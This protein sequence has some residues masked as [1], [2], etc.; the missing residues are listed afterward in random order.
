MISTLHVSDARYDSYD[1]TRVEGA[2]AGRATVH[3]GAVSRTRQQVA[4]VSIIFSTC[5]K[6]FPP[7]GVPAADPPDGELRPRGA[8]RHQ[9]ESGR[10]G[11][12]GHHPHP[13]IRHGE[14][15]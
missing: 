9:R 12:G 8:A 3:Q 7:T 11:A 2:A 15:E 14:S 6:Y 4:D 1:S 5:S 13:D 10:G